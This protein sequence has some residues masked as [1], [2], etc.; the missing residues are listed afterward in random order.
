M[1]QDEAG[2]ARPEPTD[3][4]VAIYVAETCADLARLCQREGFRTVRY[5]IGLLKM[6][7]EKLQLPPDERFQ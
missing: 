5:L 1:A 7:A 4:E 6:E 2:G 3:A